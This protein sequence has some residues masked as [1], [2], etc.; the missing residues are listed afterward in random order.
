[1]ERALGGG[2]RGV[3]RPVPLSEGMVFSV[4]GLQCAQARPWASR[5][6]SPCLGG[7]IEW[8]GLSWVCRATPGDLSS[9]AHPQGGLNKRA[10]CS[11]VRCAPRTACYIWLTY[12]LLCGAQGASSIWHGPGRCCNHEYVAGFFET[13]W[14]WATSL[15]SEARAVGG[16][17]G[18]LRAS[19]SAPE[20]P[21][22][23]QKYG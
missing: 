15:Q 4:G 6:W 12:D 7:G 2:G 23:W 9:Y 8:P 3:R 10:S 16:G 20:S 5:V 11:T 18:I 14:P 1:M 17:D 22:D 21:N 13:F 19:N